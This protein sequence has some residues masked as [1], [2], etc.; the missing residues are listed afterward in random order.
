MQIGTAFGNGGSG[1]DLSAF[2]H[3]GANLFL[4]PDVSARGR[5][6]IQLPF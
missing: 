5:A 1:S 6:G 2:P 3:V 4:Q